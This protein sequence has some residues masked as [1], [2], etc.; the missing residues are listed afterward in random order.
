MDGT[1][2]EHQQ[3]SLEVLEFFGKKWTLKVLKCLQ[4]MD[5]C[6]FN[7]LE[8]DLGVSSKTLSERLTE[9]QEFGLVEKKTYA[10][11]PPRTEYRLTDKGEALIGCFDCI[12]TWAKQWE[13]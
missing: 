11:I 7:H 1:L 12:D 3:R 6:R 9:F 8:D 2:A 4:Q 5:V 13:L 10:E